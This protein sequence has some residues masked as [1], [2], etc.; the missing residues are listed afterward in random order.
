MPAT[1]PFSPGQRPA[2]RATYSPS[3]GTNT[4]CDKGVINTLG[5][6][7]LFSSLKSAIPFQSKKARLAPLLGPHAVARAAAAD[8][9]CAR[10]LFNA[11][12]SQLTPSEQST[13]PE[14]TRGRQGTAAWGASPGDEGAVT[15]GHAARGASG[16]SFAH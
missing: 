4:S 14:G 6:N 9:G 1:R 12:P 5:E 16:P 15:G 13:R 8:V 10:G 11:N 7:L 3:S 2:L